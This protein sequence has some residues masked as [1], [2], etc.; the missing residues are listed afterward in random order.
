VGVTVAGGND[1]GSAP[2]QL[3]NPLEIYVDC[4][5]TI[6]IADFN[7]N[8]VQRWEAGA[9]SGITLVGSTWGEL[10][11]PIGVFMDSSHTLYVAEFYNHRVQRF[12]SPIVVT[13][14]PVVAGDYTAT[15]LFNGGS[16]ISNTIT[17]SA[18]KSPILPP[19]T[20]V[21]TMS[22]IV[23]NPFLSFKDYLWNDGSVNKSIEVN[24][25]G[26][27]WVEVTDNSACKGRDSIIIANKNCISKFYVPTGFTPNADGKNDLFM[28]LGSEGVKTIDFR[29]YNRWGQEVF[30]TRQVNYGWDGR[31]SGL[32][33]PI[34]A[35]VWVCTYQLQ[36]EPVRTKKGNFILIR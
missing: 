36:N 2:N 28:P 26:L 22:S 16:T 10:N 3:A 25:P 20:M 31:F 21:C 1:F 19:D 24:K 23:L 9:S 11:G 29:I 18:L 15:I 27:Y 5:G 33:Q 12:I 13:Y 34:G 14:T 32:P 30:H 4:A 6:Y 7:N 17:I 35:Y 8:R